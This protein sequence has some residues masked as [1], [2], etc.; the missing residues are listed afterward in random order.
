MNINELNF[1][2][3]I[4]TLSIIIILKNIITHFYIHSH[5]MLY[6]PNKNIPNKK[7]KSIPIVSNKVYKTA[8][9]TKN[10]EN[11]TSYL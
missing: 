4:V 7:Y 3:I 9:I 2:N 10:A 8:K 5:Y 6:S 11:S 1:F